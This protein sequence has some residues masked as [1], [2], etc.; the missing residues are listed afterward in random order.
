LF[1]VDGGANASTVKDD[2]DKE[3]V[4]KYLAKRSL[5]KSATKFLQIDK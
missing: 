1:G 3:V 2:T 4:Q 5:E